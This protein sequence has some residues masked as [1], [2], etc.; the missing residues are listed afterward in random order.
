MYAII[1]EVISVVPYMKYAHSKQKP[2]GT[3]T[4]NN[5]TSSFCIIKKRIW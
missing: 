1:Y 4:K 2:I 5:V 3:V